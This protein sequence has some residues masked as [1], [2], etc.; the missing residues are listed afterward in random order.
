MKYRYELIRDDDPMN[1]RECDNLG[2]MACWHRR[3]VLG[4][5]QP[6]ESPE[7]WIR[8]MSGLDDDQLDTAKERFYNLLANKSPPQTLSDEIALWDRADSL[9]LEKCQNLF[10]RYY[11][12][13]PLYLYDHSG[14]TMS[15]A[16]FSCPWDSGQVGIIYVSKERL[17]QEYSVRA[18]TQA[19]R[20][21]ALAVLRAEVEEY[22][23]YLTGDCWGYEI[24]EMDDDPDMI[25]AG[26]E[27][28]GYCA[29]PPPRTRTLDSC[30]GFLGY[31]YAEEAAQEAMDYYVQ[32]DAEN[33]NQLTLFPDGNETASIRAAYA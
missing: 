9:L 26:Y 29:N 13:L 25:A 22:D 23:R 15:C 19:I 5:E 31:E 7:E 17:R 11:L 14:V 28:D 16:A 20:E 4:D 24:Y 30:W 3:Y 33:P 18:I 21:K 8:N 1:P 32:K 6:S 10:D 27:N 12:S 2:T